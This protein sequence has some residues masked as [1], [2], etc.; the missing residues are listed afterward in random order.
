[1]DT[2]LN[3]ITRPIYAAASPLLQSAFLQ[4]YPHLQ[5]AYEILYPLYTRI[6]YSL[7][8]MA[9]PLLTTFRQF[10]NEDP[11]AAGIM[12]LVFLLALFVTFFTLFRRLVVFGISLAMGLVFWGAVGVLVVLVWEGGVE[13]MGEVIARLRW[14]VEVFWREYKEAVER[15]KMQSR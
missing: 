14:F 10:A 5:H 1:M 7:L 11:L 15:E 9:V 3:N 6:V 12:L 4:A 13:K 2:L 8:R